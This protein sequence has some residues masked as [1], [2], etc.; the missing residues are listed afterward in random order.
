MLDERAKNR[1]KQVMLEAFDQQCDEAAKYLQ[2]IINVFINMLIK[3]GMLKEAAKLAIDFDGENPDDV[4]TVI[5]NLPEESS[6]LTPGNHCIHFMTAPYT[7]ISCYLQ[8]VII[9]LLP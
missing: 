7:K 5:V 9:S 1:H 4:R 2:I 6:S 8:N 3:R